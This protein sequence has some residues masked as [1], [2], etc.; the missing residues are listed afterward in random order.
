MQLDDYVRN[1]V[2]EVVEVF[3]INDDVGLL[4]DVAGSA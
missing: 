2:M 3:P 1:V 4:S